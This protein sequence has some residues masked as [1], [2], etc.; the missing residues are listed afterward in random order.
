MGDLND[1]LSNINNELSSLLHSANMI[2]AMATFDEPP[3]NLATYA[4]GIKRIDHVFITRGLK[5]FITRIG[6][7]PFNDII[8]S[9]HRMMFLDLDKKLFTASLETLVPPKKRGVTGKDKKS[10]QIYCNKL[11]FLCTE[12]KLFQKTKI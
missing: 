3:E 7:T 8:F 10:I 1:Y 11:H 12:H 5:E 4:R 6:Y 2:D 9:D